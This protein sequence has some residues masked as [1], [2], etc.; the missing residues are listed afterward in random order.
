MNE[1]AKILILWFLASPTL[2]ISI[3][4]ASFLRLVGTELGLGLKKTNCI[5]FAV[6]M[7]IKHGG[8]ILIRKSDYGWYPHFL[9]A[10]DV[11]GK[12]VVHIGPTSGRPPKNPIDFFTFEAYIRGGDDR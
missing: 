11:N 5:I 3:L 10:K 6:S 1:R 2:L 7:W 4:I 8:Y 9:W 12:T